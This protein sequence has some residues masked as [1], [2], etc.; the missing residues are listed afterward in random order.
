MAASNGGASCG[1][2]AWLPTFGSDPG[3]DGTV[4]SAVVF[5]D[6]TGPSLHVG[7]SFTAAGTLQSN[8]IARWNGSEW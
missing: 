4:L 8:R 7:G 2:L 6:G 3:L 5:D 1:N